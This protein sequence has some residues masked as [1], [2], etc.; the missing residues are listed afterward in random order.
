MPE[1]RLQSLVLR[2][3]VKFSV[4]EGI[5]EPVC[6]NYPIEFPTLWTPQ[7]GIRFLDALMYIDNVSWGVELKVSNGQEYRHAITQAVL[8][9]EFIKRETRLH[10][11]FKKRIPSLDASKCRAGVVFQKTL[12]ERIMR[13]HERVATV[14]GIEVLKL[15]GE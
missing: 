1:R 14:F 15:K 13:M 9:R 12:P 8:Y 4:E 5:L 6:R 2:N 11:W 10:S 3:V 7:G